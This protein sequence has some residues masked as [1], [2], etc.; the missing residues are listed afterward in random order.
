MIVVLVPEVIAIENMYHFI[1]N[2]LFRKVKNVSQGIRFQGHRRPVWDRRQN[3]GIKNLRDFIDY[4]KRSFSYVGAI[5][6]HELAGFKIHLVLNMVR[7]PQD[8]LLG[9]SIRSVMMKYLGISIEYSGYVENNDAV[10]KSV[11]ERKPFM[12]NFLATGCAKEIEVLVE[13]LLG[14]PGK[15]RS[16]EASDDRRQARRLLPNPGGGPPGEPAGDPQRLHPV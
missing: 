12:Q 5:L 2:A 1:K 4:L 15:S 3:Y 11:R 6:D 7:N 10:W 9:A 16:P 14:G 8:I 13:N